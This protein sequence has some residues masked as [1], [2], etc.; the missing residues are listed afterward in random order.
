VARHRCI[1][2]MFRSPGPL[3]VA[4]VALAGCEGPAEPMTT[5]QASSTG[6]GS[7]GGGGTGEATGTGASTGEE[8]TDAGETTGSTGEADGSAATT[9]A[10]DGSTGTAVDACA[11]NILTWENFGEPFMLT[12][13]TGCHHSSI[14]TAER[15]NAP[16]GVNLDSH[17]DVLFWQ[18]RI[19]DRAV[20]MKPT[21][22]PPAA[23]IPEDDLA[24]LKQYIE[25]GAPGPDA[26]QMSMCPDPP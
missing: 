22:M 15:A 25:C 23:I 6:A 18:Q 11:E 20:V 7:T 5:A 13:C 24:L 4:F 8:A 14:P 2:E 3:L 1:V 21:P 19:L 12:W 10:T 17:G 9:D 16:C 26:A